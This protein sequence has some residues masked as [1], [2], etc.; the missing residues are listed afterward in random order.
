MITK[1]HIALAIAAIL[2]VGCSYKSPTLNESI[3]YEREQQQRVKSSVNSSPA[4]FLSPPVSNQHVVFTSGSSVSTSLSMSRNKAILDAQSQLADQIS[5]V[6]SGITKQYERDYGVN[7]VNSMVDTEVV[8]RKI[9]SEVD[10]SG[11]RIE[12]VEIKPEGRFY[13][14]YVLLAYP[15]GENNTLREMQ[16]NRQAMQRFSQDRDAAFNELNRNSR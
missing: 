1:K 15:I 6:I 16:L 3:R 4:W 2:S 9:V 13:R 10:I 12:Q 7:T 14:T 5:S 8:V 11:Y